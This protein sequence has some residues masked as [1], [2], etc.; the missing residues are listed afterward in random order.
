MG[1]Q[2]N[3]AIAALQA[4]VNVITNVEAGARTGDVGFDATTRALLTDA[5]IGTFLGTI[6]DYGSRSQQNTVQAARGTTGAQEA[7][8]TQLT[9]YVADINAHIAKLQNPTSVPRRQQ[10]TLL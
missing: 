2:T 5:R 4:L 10:T 9:N 1:V 3:N 6:L 8:F 7:A